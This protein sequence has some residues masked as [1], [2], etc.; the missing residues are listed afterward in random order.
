MACRL[1]GAKSLHEPMVIL[2]QIFP[3]E[4]AFENIIGKMAAILC[5]PQGVKLHA[6]IIWER[7]MAHLICFVEQ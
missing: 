5:R 6:F 1:W 4:N 3:S 2:S 7:G